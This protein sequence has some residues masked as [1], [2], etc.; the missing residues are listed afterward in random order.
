MIIVLPIPDPALAPNSRTHPLKKAGI[1]RKHRQAAFFATLAALGC[2]NLPTR[3]T[4]KDAKR[5]GLTK[6]GRNAD[7]YRRLSALLF[8]DEPPK[9]S[10]YTLAFY[11]PDRR[12]RDDDNAAASC[13]AYRDGIA[14]ALRIDDHH[15]RQSGSASM[16]WDANDPRVEIWMNEKGQR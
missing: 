9:P 12:H 1:T 5:L 14:D 3:I 15:L 16:A 8:P 10:T 13:K 7:F 11:F 2:R 6:A 4:L